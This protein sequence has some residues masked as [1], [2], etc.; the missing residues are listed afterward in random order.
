M[1]PGDKVVCVDF[2]PNS[3]TGEVPPLLPNQV[4]VI[5]DAFYS[6]RW[7]GT[8]VQLIGVFINPIEYCGFNAKRFRKLEELKN[9][10][11]QQNET[12]T[13]NEADQRLASQV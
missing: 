11:K 8:A 7:R 13:S 1:N 3:V 12:N 10:R 9:E 5:K 2:T 4:Y 6:A